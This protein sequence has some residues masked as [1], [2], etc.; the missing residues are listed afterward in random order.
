VMSDFIFAKGFALAQSQY[1]S[2][3]PDDEPGGDDDEW[4][5]EWR[6]REARAEAQEARYEDR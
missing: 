4:Y 6:E 3:E 1:D 5:D 2:A